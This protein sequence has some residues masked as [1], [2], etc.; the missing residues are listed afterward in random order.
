[1]RAFYPK[2]FSVAPGRSPPVPVLGPH[3]LADFHLSVVDFHLAKGD[4]QWS[5][6]AVGL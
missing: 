6:L 2:V 5:P 4:L 3:L 1:M